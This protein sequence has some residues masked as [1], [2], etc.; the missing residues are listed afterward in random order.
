MNNLASHTKPARPEDFADIRLAAL[1]PGDEV[2]PLGLSPV[3]AG[4]PSPAEDYAEGGLN[5]HRGLPSC[6]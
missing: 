2:I 4:F 6:A 5:V 1:E 3:S